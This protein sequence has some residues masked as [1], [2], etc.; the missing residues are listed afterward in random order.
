[1]ASANPVNPQSFNRYTYALNNPTRFTDP[2]GLI[3]DSDYDGT[4]EKEKQQ[5]EIDREAQENSGPVLAEVEVK[6]DTPPEQQLIRQDW[7]Y[8]EVIT[9]LARGSSRHP[10]LAVFIDEEVRTPF[11]DAFNDLLWEYAQE[12]AKLGEQDEQTFAGWFI[13]NRAYYELNGGVGFPAGV[14]G[15]GAIGSGQPP[16]LN[17]NP[18]KEREWRDK[19]LATLKGS[20]KEREMKNHVINI[21]NRTSDS[22]RGVGIARARANDPT[23]IRARDTAEKRRMYDQLHKTIGGGLK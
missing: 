7:Y 17:I 3:T 20:P 11:P 9:R 12:E 1:M 6:D 15:G 16:P 10:L 2:T 18:Q 23:V 22:A 21:M 4:T 14:S 8:V 19:L 5:K 13:N